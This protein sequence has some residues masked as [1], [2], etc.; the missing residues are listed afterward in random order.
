ME[1]QCQNGWFFQLDKLNSIVIVNRFRWIGAMFR[2]ITGCHRNVAD[3]LNMGA[4]QIGL[5]TEKAAVSAGEMGN[6]FHIQIVLNL[7]A[8]MTAR[9]PR[10][11]RSSL[12]EMPVH[13]M[14]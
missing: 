4:E 11:R 6:S 10:R 13:P 9:H 1:N 14:G 8:S 12:Q 2:R 7:A 5:G 3:T